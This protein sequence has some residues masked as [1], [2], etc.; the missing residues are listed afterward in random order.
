MY[1]HSEIRKNTLYPSVI[2]EKVFHHEFP[3]T[4]SLEKFSVFTNY[5]GLQIS[6][7]FHLNACQKS[8]CLRL[9]SCTDILCKLRI[10]FEV[11]LPLNR[12][13]YLPHVRKLCS[14][15]E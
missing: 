1:L 10:T 14:F 11:E 7:E 12:G 15:V 5:K 3:I 13:F 6:P 9:N 2:T 4:I 8:I